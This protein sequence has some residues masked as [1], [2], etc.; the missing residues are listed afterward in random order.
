VVAGLSGLGKPLTGEFVHRPG[1]FA[2]LSGLAP[3]GIITPD[4][5]IRI[6]SHPDGG[7]KNIPTGARRLVLLNQADTPGDRSI[8]G[9]LAQELLKTFDAVIVGALQHAYVQTFE[10]CAGIVLAA[11]KASRFGQ[12]KQLLDFRGQPFVRVV[13][14]NAL[15]GGLSPVVVVTGANAEAVEAALQDLPVL[16]LRNTDWENGQSSSIKTG[17]QAL[18]PA[19]RQVGSPVFNQ[20]G[21]N[22]PEAG[23]AIFLLADQPQIPPTLVQALVNTH[24]L[25]LAPIVA[26]FVRDRRA[27]PVLFDRLT[28]P[29][30]LSLTGDVGGR[31]IFNK[32]P[33]TQLPWHDENVLMDIDT[34]EDL[35]RLMDVEQ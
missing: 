34:P 10:P 17:L 35:E 1:I 27:N 7:L 18:L 9:K 26:P 25:E 22:R 33:V 14:K 21:A 32:Y 12:P 5:L 3:G 23:A 15:A 28:F 11:G 16:I 8:G 29:D 2:R 30:L 6:L 20:S 24:S 4:A 19:P 13:A 31:A